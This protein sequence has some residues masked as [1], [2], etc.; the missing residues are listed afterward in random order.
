MIHFTQ[1]IGSKYRFIT[2]AAQRCDQLIRGAKPRV[3]TRSCKY[4]TIAQEEVLAGLIEE[5]GEEPA[6]AEPVPL[7]EN[8]EAEP[9]SMAEPAAEAVAAEAAPAA[10]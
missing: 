1:D 6:L 10:D 8:A 2:M 7:R 3:E 4:T 5:R 9:V